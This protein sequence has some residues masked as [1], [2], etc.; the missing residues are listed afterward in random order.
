[1]NKR[2]IAFLISDMGAGGAQRVASIICSDWAERG[3]NVT[4]MTFEPPDTQGFHDLHPDISY[5][6]LGI[7]GGSGNLLKAIPANIKRARAVRSVCREVNA[8][9][10]ISFLPEMNVLAVLSS[11]GWKRYPVIVSERSEPR[12]I[13]AQKLWRFLRVITYPFTSGLVCQTPRAADFFTKH[14]NCCVIANPLPAPPEHYN[15]VSDFKT[16]GPFIAGLG[17]LGHE[18]GFDLLI[19]AFA[20]VHDQFPDHHL[21]IFGEGDQRPTLEAQIKSLGLAKFIHLPGQKKHPFSVLKDADLFVVPS[22]FE[23]F[24][25]ALVEAMAHGMAVITSDGAAQSLEMIKNDENAIITNDT[26]SMIEGICNLLSDKERA[27]QFGKN[28]RHI[29]SELDTDKICRQWRNFIEGVV[30]HE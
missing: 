27:M 1:M 5:R 12:I 25:N 9:I 6:K 19:E 13:P 3:D 15:E 8:D 18:K 26:K 11:F 30:S 23:G 10:L 29:C 4:L 17:R 16:P 2:N 14:K 7:S 28:A 24:P 20:R 22:R 21:V